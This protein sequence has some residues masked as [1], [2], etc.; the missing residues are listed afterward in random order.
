[1]AEFVMGRAGSDYKQMWR[2][3][4]G[5]CGFCVTRNVPFALAISRHTPLLTV[6]TGRE[7][8]AIPVG[9]V[10][11]GNGVCVCVCMSASFYLTAL[12]CRLINGS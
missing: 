9:I 7:R 3:N 6:I 10:C 4:L 12:I 2:L 5:S 11:G 8:C 1:M